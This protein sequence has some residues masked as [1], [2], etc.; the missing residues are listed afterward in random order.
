M[1]NIR[2]ILVPVDFSGPSAQA[3]QYALRLAEQ[4]EVDVTL[5]HVAAP[6]RFDFAMAEP[7]SDRYNELLAERR[8]H[9]RRAL[10]D[11]AEGALAGAGVTREFSEG[12]AADE[13]M[14]RAHNGGFGAIVMSTRGAGPLRRWL[15]VGSVTS[16]VLYGADCPVIS[17][18]CFDERFAPV[19]PR[20]ILCAI[21]LGPQSERAL[22]FSSDLAGRFGAS[23]SVIH[24]APAMGEATADFFDDSWRATLRSRLREK[25]A[26]LL[27]T[28]EIE[29][30]IVVEV[31]SP[32]GTIA[33]AARI[34]GAGL[35]VL[36]RGVSSD[37]IGRLSASGY[38]IV[39]ESPCP[40]VTV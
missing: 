15:L 28:L 9:I 18:S 23:L 26:A 36:G 33:Q 4:F 35:L 3:A 25:T 16:K 29:A 13:I 12:D 17:C 21:D 30:D 37:L 1:L 34:F 7:L 31:G 11:L 20:Q 10:E 27:R 40:V 8:E 32:P 24:A 19:P 39:R 5:L 2:K 14:R 22:R 38:D 6:L